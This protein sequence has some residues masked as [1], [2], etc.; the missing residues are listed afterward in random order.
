[1]EGTLQVYAVGFEP[2]PAGQRTT[3][4]RIRSV[5]LIFL[6]F[7]LVTVLGTGLLLLPA[8]T[9]AGEQPDLMHALFT[10]TSA[11]CV[12]GLVVVDTA[13]HWSPFG[14]AVI[15]VLIQLG[16]FGQTEASSTRSPTPHPR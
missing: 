15:L 12:T 3:L 9:V 8:A 16:G 14:Q 1:M 13:T 2:A 4:R 5:R 7:F 6:G 10:S 11:L